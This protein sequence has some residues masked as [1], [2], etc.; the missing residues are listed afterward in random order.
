VKRI[1]AKMGEGQRNAGSQPPAASCAA[2]FAG[3]PQLYGRLDRTTPPTASLAHEQSPHPTQAFNPPTSGLFHAAPLR[4]SP[5]LG[6]R[7]TAGL[8]RPGGR[9]LHPR[10]RRCPLRC[11]NSWRSTVHHLAD[12]PMTRPSSPGCTRSRPRQLPAH[13]PHSPA[14]TTASRPREPTTPASDSAA[15]HYRPSWTRLPVRIAATRYARGSGQAKEKH[16]VS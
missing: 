2:L 15:R 5:R 4:K 16:P 1:P 7:G 13:W 3:S 9:H 6:T 12:T 11:D 8:Y 10:R 14:R